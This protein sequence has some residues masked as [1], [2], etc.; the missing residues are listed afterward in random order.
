M[1]VPPIIPDTRSVSGG[2]I[3]REPNKLGS[4][5]IV[6]ISVSC[7]GDRKK[8]SSW[9]LGLGAALAVVDPTVMLRALHI[10]FT[11]SNIDVTD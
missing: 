1:D 3:G 7:S 5:V 9:G 8:D 2:G 10:V 6:S 4:T 11:E